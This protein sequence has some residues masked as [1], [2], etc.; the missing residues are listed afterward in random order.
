VIAYRDARRGTG[1]RLRIVDGALRAVSLAGD[2]S[3]ASWLRDYLERGEP[4]AAISRLLLLPGARPP[5]ASAPRGKTICQCLG[6]SENAIGSWLAARSSDTCGAAAQLAG[7]QD[8]L[9]CG[10][11]CGSCLPEL[12][13][14]IAHAAALPTS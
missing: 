9:K 2:I 12:R 6:V 11:Q 5:V 3:A 7:L 8:A 1:R 14:M 4:V 10:T 13:R